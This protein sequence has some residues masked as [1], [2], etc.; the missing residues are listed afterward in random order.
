MKWRQEY[1]LDRRTAL[2]WAATLW[3]VFA[4][5]LWNPS[6]LQFIR[7]KTLGRPGLHRFILNSTWASDSWRTKARL[8]LIA[9]G[10]PERDTLLVEQI[11]A[12]SKE[13]RWQ[14]VSRLSESKSDVAFNAFLTLA[15][16]KDIEVQR[17]AIRHLARYGDGRAI[18]IL[19]DAIHNDEREVAQE[20]INGLGRLDAIKALPVLMEVLGQAEAKDVLSDYEVMA[21]SIAAK[22]ARQPY[23]FKE[24]CKFVHSCLDLEP[25]RFKMNIEKFPERAAELKAERSAAHLA[26]KRAL[27]NSKKVINDRRRLLEWWGRESGQRGEKK[28]AG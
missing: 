15:S 4:L 19:L 13:R 12:S 9:L 1:H 10:V 27:C 7:R 8:N 17:Y 22:L 26:K 6:P 14:W 3:V 25:L 16:D 18:P 5:L 11:N 21:G 20:A 23:A 2:R 24:E 28:R